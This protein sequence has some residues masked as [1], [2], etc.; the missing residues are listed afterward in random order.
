MATPPQ[1]SDQSHRIAVCTTCRPVQ[2][3]SA[4]GWELIR[5]LRAALASAAGGVAQRFSGFGIACMAGCARPCTVA[6][7]AS[8]KATYLF[9]DI[10]PADDVGPLV[11][12]A[13]LYETSA[14]GWTRSGERPPA[15]AGKTLARV[16]ALS[17][18]A[19]ADGEIA[20]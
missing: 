12:F 8:G 5:R 14:D 6:F 11:T 10:D 3:A 7:Q 19:N 16:P 13:Q 9:G 2:S 4:P 15:L 1:P 18:D 20:T 17:R